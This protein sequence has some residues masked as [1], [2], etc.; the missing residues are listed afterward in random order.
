MGTNFNIVNRTINLPPNLTDIVVQGDT[1][2]KTI[3]FEMTRYFDGVDLASKAIKIAYMN[4]KSESGYSDAFVSQ[5]DINTFTFSWSVP[6]EITKEF[7]EVQISVEFSETDTSNKKI[8]VWK[9][10]P[11]SFKV[12]KSFQVLG[13]ATAQ[14]YLL[15]Q[16]FYLN[17]TNN[18]TSDI[19]DF[20]EPIYISNRRILMPVIE[21]IVVSGDTR[22]QIISF[23]LPRYFEN[24]DLS[25]KVISVKF[26]NA[27]NQGDRSSVVNVV[28]TDDAI[29]FGWLID[30]K[31]TVKEGYVNFAIEFLGYDE[32]N[33]FY[34]WSTTPAQVEV[35]K[36][37]VVDELID[38]PEPS[39]IQSWELS[40]DDRI[41]RKFNDL[42]TAKQI[43]SEVILARGK[44]A[45]LRQ[46]LDKNDTLLAQIENQKADKNEVSN[47]L[48]PKGNSLYGNLPTTNN[49]IGDYYYCIDGDGNNSAGNYV[50]NGSSWYFGGTGDQGYNLLKK[51]LSSIY[52]DQ[53]N[54]VNLAYETYI[55]NI[56]HNYNFSDTYRIV[57]ADTGK[58]EKQASG[59][60]V[61]YQLIG[62]ENG[63]Y[64]ENGDE[65]YIG[66]STT[67]RA[68]PRVFCYDN[69]HNY[70][71]VL[72]PL[73]IPNT[74][75]GWYNVE[76][77]YC[78]KAELLS[79]TKYI[80][81]QCN[82]NRA[83][84]NGLF[85]MKHKINIPNMI[86]NESQVKF[87]RDSDV[88]SFSYKEKKP[89]VVFIS[90]D[91]KLED[92]TELKPVFKAKGVP[93]VTAVVTNL[94]GTSSYMTLSQLKELEADGWEIASH[95]M[96]HVRLSDLS[97]MAQVTDEMTNSKE[98]LKKW[99]FDVKSLVYP[100][101]SVTVDIAREAQKHYESAVD[102]SGEG[103][104][105]T[106]ALYTYQLHRISLG[107]YYQGTGQDTL[108]FYK[109]KVDSAISNNALLIFMLHPNSEEHTDEQTQHLSNLIDYI[110]SLN[111]NI[112]TLS[113][114]LSEVGNMY[115]V[116]LHYKTSDTDYA[117][118]FAI[119]C[120]GKP[121][122]SSFDGMNVK[123]HSGYGITSTTPL[124]AFELNKT[125]ICPIKYAQRAGFPFNYGILI[126][127]HYLDKDFSSQIMISGTE[128]RIAHRKWN[129]TAWKVFEESTSCNV[130]PINTN[131]E[132]QLITSYKMGVS[133]QAVRNWSMGSG[134]LTTYRTGNNGLDFQK[135]ENQNII[136]KR[137]TNE[138]GTWATWE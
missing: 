64:I 30:G 138:D 126:T 86:V 110:K 113:D 47:V 133:I 19:N 118:Y 121:Y 82:T 44:E 112:M 16:N 114:A 88:S 18:D 130:V 63:I 104:L 107:S 83:I 89:I 111:V 115:E 136:K 125:T 116:G 84:S 76:G 57:N 128:N 77:Y 60:S 108:E 68:L 48:T 101:G 54:F 25:S 70:L 98:R 58:V 27:K 7:G 34:C 5:L 45:S 100:Y 97:T 132:S 96:N 102:V 37:L 21:D 74:E 117:D 135:L 6:G 26:I 49:Q 94:V 52:S 72:P 46:R 90:D 13:N 14:S 32:N 42:S 71:G 31:V 22:S 80:I 66:E 43:D 8:Y 103:G 38:E 62:H 124:T 23:T 127:N 105:N 56:K 93:C 106:G 123:Y 85:L 69:F 53:L 91:G 29:S 75:N 87:S 61:V 3:I 28:T 137:G 95:T 40:A 99:G 79:G 51:D 15:Q 78:Q 36:G 50:W 11:K 120:D 59:A 33:K 1:N 10:K 65:V 24:T 20:N 73:P 134:I 4:A 55:S 109:A 2:S 92:Y 39:W 131:T 122:G 129:G 12:E 41:N 119:A 35:S 17:N 67:E 9:T 81:I